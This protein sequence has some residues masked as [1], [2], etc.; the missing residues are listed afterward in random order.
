MRSSTGWAILF[1][2]HRLCGPRAAT[3]CGCRQLARH[4]GGASCEPLHLSRPTMRHVRQKIVKSGRPH[5]PTNALIGD[6][7]RPHCLHPGRLRR[8]RG[9]GLRN[10]HRMGQ[11]DAKAE[12]LMEAA[13]SLAQGT[14]PADVVAGLAMARLTALRKPY[15][16]VRGIAAGHAFRRFVARTL[17]KEWAQVFDNGTRPYQFALQARAGTDALAASVRAALSLRP[18]SVL[19]SLDGRSACDSMS[20]AQPSS[21]NYARSRRSSS[22]LCV[23]LRP[24]LQLQ[25]VR[26]HGGLSDRAARRRMRAGRCP[27]PSAV[28]ARPTR[29]TLSICGRAAPG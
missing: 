20:P 12:S 22:P 18:R 24:A 15:G 28:R 21:A 6:W 25:L 27:C 11:A 9:M 16:G 14:V 8:K 2:L 5:S 23:V 29:S 1:F 13:T 26:R 3:L 17:A 19:V 10:R 4:A 7:R